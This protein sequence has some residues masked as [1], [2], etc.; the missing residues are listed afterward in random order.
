MIAKC[1]AGIACLA[2]VALAGYNDVATDMPWTQGV[3]NVGALEVVTTA[4]GLKYHD[5][6]CQGQKFARGDTVQV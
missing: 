5:V 2:A 1:L 4:S 6:V 3:S